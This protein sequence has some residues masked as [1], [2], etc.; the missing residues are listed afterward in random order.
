MAEIVTLS[1][2]SRANFGGMLYR[3]QV[4]YP[5]HVWQSG[6]LFAP[7]LQVFTEA[8]MPGKYLG[9]HEC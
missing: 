8:S 9:N 3:F 2:K 6:C 5:A 7:I 1:I 4:L